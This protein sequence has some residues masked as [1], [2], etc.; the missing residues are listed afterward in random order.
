MLS[1][2]VDVGRVGRY[3]SNP[4]KRRSFPVV[5]CSNYYGWCLDTDDVMM[6]TSQTQVTTTTKTTSKETKSLS[7]CRI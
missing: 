5:S 1:I 2:L 3:M 4:D 6:D 7:F